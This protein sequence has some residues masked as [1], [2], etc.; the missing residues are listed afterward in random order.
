MNPCVESQFDCTVGEFKGE[1]KE[2]EG[3]IS[4]VYSE[5]EIS[6]ANQHKGVTLCNVTGMEV[7]KNQSLHP[8]RQSETGQ[9]LA[10]TSSNYLDP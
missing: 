8:Q 3:Y 10:V 6:K 5:Y 7:S 2:M 4:K 9:T 1:V